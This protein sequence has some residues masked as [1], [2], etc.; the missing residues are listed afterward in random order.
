ME[1][2]EMIQ[3]LEKYVTVD[4][5]D[6]IVIT[7]PNK[8]ITPVIFR[9]AIIKTGTL[10]EEDILTGTYVGIISAGI[11][12]SNKCYI[13][14]KV[15]KDT[16][17]LIAFAKEGLIKQDTAAHA[18]KE[19]SNTLEV[20]FPVKSKRKKY[21]L[22]IIVLLICMITLVS[23]SV[24]ES[25]RQSTARYN[26]AVKDFNGLVVEYQRL[27]NS[28]CMETIEG[29]PVDLDELPYESTDTACLIKS[30]IKGNSTE[31]VEADINNIQQLSEYLR[32]CITIAES[33]NNP[34]SDWV[35]ERL[36]T[37]DDIDEIQTVTKETDVN[38]LLGK[39]GGYTSCIYFSSSKI[40][41]DLV[42]GKNA[43]EKGADGG[44]AIE[45]FSSKQD[46]QERCEY[47]AKRDNTIYY[48]GSYA[49]VG[50]MVVRTSAEFENKE[51][52]ALTDQIINAFT[53]MQ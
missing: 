33:I 38:G 8:E 9:D 32:S 27:N 46:A 44:G 10:L 29:M 5:R 35:I 21:F 3:R 23:M 52:L 50:T 20:S 31:K 28:V 12:N 37:I 39:E 4:Q 40:P 16:I 11:A 53:Q 17:Y 43:L 7:I 6:L 47:F 48:S 36:K 49:L 30:I 24:T 42:S 19:L 18:L 14:G 1:D 26:A 34:S 22:W 45:V 15:S 13:C 25:F 2:K 41:N 51:Q